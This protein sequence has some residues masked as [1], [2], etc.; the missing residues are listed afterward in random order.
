M[1]SYESSIYIQNLSLKIWQVREEAR[2]YFV[3]T[4]CPEAWAHLII[5]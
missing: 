3:I 2:Y 4:I 5:G 1:V